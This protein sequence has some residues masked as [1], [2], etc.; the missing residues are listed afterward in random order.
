MITRW[1]RRL[2]RLIAETADLLAVVN[3]G[4]QLV[5]RRELSVRILSYRT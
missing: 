1:W 4:R 2:G 3:D 5:N